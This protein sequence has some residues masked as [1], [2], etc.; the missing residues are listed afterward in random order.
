MDTRSVI[1]VLR[2]NP[3]AMIRTYIKEEVNDMVLLLF[4]PTKTEPEQR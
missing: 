3:E 2:Y 1:P 4:Y